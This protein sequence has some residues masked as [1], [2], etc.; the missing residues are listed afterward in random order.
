MINIYYVIVSVGQ[1]L[2]SSLAGWFWLRVSDE[3]KSR[4]WLGLQSSEC[5]TGAGRSTSNLT[6][7]AFGSWQ[8]ASALCHMDLSIGLLTTW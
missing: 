5:S 2:G 7:V 6:H 1:E 4:C 8:E 3:T